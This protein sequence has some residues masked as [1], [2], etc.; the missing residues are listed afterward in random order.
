[1]TTMY[2]KFH[3]YASKKYNTLK[4]CWYLTSVLFIQHILN[5][6]WQKNLNTLKKR[7]KIPV[8]IFHH[9]LTMF[10][11]VQAK[12]SDEFLHAPADSQVKP[13]NTCAVKSP[14]N[15]LYDFSCGIILVLISLL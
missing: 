10:R 4:L 7:E 1:M 13:A 2:H 11:Q 3:D 5:S 14:T 9:G 15:N 8:T 6:F 12:K